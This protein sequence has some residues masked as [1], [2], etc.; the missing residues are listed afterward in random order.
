M[1]HLP[2]CL[3]KKPGLASLNDK[4]IR[5]RIAK[6]RTRPQA[7]RWTKRERVKHH[8]GES[9][10][11]LSLL[12]LSVFFFPNAAAKYDTMAWSV[13]GA[14]SASQHVLCDLLPLRAALALHDH[15][16]QIVAEC[17]VCLG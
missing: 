5:I 2:S 14:G 3:G 15:A 11:E 1:G 17:P 7:G 4:F 9:T 16:A 6:R 10:R 12:I 8:I 13:T